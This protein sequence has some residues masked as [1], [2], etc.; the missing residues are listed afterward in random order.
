[1]DGL[2]KTYDPNDFNPKPGEVYAGLPNEVYHSLHDWYSSS[3]IKNALVDYRMV[4]VGRNEKKSTQALEIGTAIHMMIENYPAWDEDLI[5]V[6]P[7]DSFGVKWQKVKDEHPNNPVLSLRLKRETLDMALSLTKRIE[8]EGYFE[9]SHYHELSL[10][11]IDEESGVKCRARIDLLVPEFEAILDW[12]KTRKA[13]IETFKSDIGN[14]GYH[15]SMAFYL[16]AVKNVIDH[17]YNGA[18]LITVFDQAPYFTNKVVIGPES[19][20]AGF[21]A[22]SKGLDVIAK[23]TVIDS[24]IIELSDYHLTRYL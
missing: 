22:I 13:S 16:E 18:G 10:F 1:M 12:K 14:F 17:R 8:E 6:S 5:I 24:E 23:K 3:D 21:N 11:W 9:G 7:T 15:I 2:I 4:E 20:I 19:L